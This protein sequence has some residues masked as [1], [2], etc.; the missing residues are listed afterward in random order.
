[1]I[2]CT[3]LAFR[4]RPYERS[5]NAKLCFMCWQKVFGTRLHSFALLQE[6]YFIAPYCSSHSRV[7]VFPFCFSYELR[8]QAVVSFFFYDFSTST[9]ITSEASQSFFPL[10]FTPSLGNFYDRKRRQRVGFFWQSKSSKSEP[11]TFIIFSYH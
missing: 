10:V 5:E 7:Y 8:F 1:M 6:C 3:I 11:L 4:F 9:Y 2:F